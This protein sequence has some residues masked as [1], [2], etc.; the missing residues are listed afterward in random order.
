MLLLCHTTN[1]FYTQDFDLFEQALKI[2][3]QARD[4]LEH[5][6][7]NHQST[8]PNQ[9]QLISSKTIQQ[10]HHS[11]VQPF[12]CR[13]RLAQS[14]YCVSSFA[15]EVSS[16]CNLLA[17]NWMCIIVLLH[18]Y[19]SGQRNLVLLRVP[20]FGSPAGKTS[21]RI[22]TDSEERIEQRVKSVSS[23]CT[24][25]QISLHCNHFIP[26]SAGAVRMETRQSKVQQKFVF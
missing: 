2:L 20:K 17:E 6:F 13:R 9:I 1:D 18:N 24:R 22:S 26:V 12:F 10:T 3:S 4:N 23:N 25:L 19:L 11:V 16:S 15:V 5:L 14:E 7:E 8:C 21:K